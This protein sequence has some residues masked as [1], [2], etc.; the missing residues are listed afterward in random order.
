MKSLTSKKA[1]A[2]VTVTVLVVLNQE[3]KEREKGIGFFVSCFRFTSR[4]SKHDE[5][6]K[7]SASKVS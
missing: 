7:K 1:T 4:Q 3:R 6:K 5:N 2:M